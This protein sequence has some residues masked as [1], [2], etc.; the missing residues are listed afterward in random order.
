MQST[1]EDDARLCVVLA[2]A[3]LTVACSAVFAVTA[4][5]TDVAQGWLLLLPAYLPI[6]YLFALAGL[7]NGPVLQM[8]SLVFI[9][10]LS[11]ACYF[12]MTYGIACAYR[13][14]HR[15]N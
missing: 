14:K 11:F 7:P 4:G 3:I 13:R 12:G 5:S 8:V 1:S 2:A 10:V 6:K 9:V 15:H